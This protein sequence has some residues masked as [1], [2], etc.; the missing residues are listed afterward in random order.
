[1]TDIVGYTQVSAGLRRGRRPVAAD[2][3]G[4]AGERKQIGPYFQRGAG[5]QMERY[6]SRV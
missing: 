2:G 5:I 1:M 3:K 6:A 4:L